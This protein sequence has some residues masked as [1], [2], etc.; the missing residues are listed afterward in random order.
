[1]ADQENKRDFSPDD[2]L[3]DLFKEPTNSF[4]GDRSLKELFNERISAL[5]ITPTNVLDILKIQYRTLNGILN[6]T[7]KIVDFTNLVKLADF[8]QLSREKVIQLYIT[9][10][11]KNLTNDINPS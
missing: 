8:L 4:E 6:G 10:L 9:E 1:M 7:Q 2:L 3:R 11:E 5:N